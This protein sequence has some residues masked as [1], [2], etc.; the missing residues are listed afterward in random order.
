MKRVFAAAFAFSLITAGAQARELSEREKLAREIYEELIETD[1][2]HSTG[3]TT[4]AAEAMAKRL[5]A[6]GVPERDVRVLGPGKRRFAAR[7]EAE[8]SEPSGDRTVASAV[9]T[10]SGAASSATDPEE[11]KGNLVARLR[12]QGEPKQKPLLLLAHLDVV[13]AKRTD[14]SLDPFTL[15]ERDGFFYG[16]GTI[17]NKAMAAIYVALAIELTRE[18]TRL[19]RDVILALTADEEGGGQNGARWLVDEKRELVDAGLVINEGGHGALRGGKHFYL[20]LQAAEKTS[21]NFELVAR[22]KGGHSS[23]PAPGNAIYRLAA[24]LARVEKL[25]FPVELNEVTRA[26][27]ERLARIEKGDGARAMAALVKN[28]RDAAAVRQLS[29]QPTYNATLRTTCV[30]TQI[31]GGHAPNALPQEARALVNCRALPGHAQAEVERALVAAVGDPSIALTALRERESSAPA[32]VDRKFLG[33]VTR[34][35]N[36]MWPGVPVIPT[37]GTGAT[38]STYFRLA[39]IPAY[40]VSGLFDDLDDYRAHGRDERLGVAQFYDGLEFLRRLVRE[41]AVRA[42]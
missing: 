18:K 30:A 41:L 1:T 5:R 33:A 38:D 32:R 26:Y 3:S 34:V 21:M 20:A 27:F 10:G 28:P 12:A 39:G 7:S 23:R 4:L 40:G 17:D 11:R 6:A 29:A 15:T 2:T 13:E 14:W 36:S 9:G 19:S 25:A 35:S 37:M 8:S 22:D 16:R 24:A 42:D 31:S